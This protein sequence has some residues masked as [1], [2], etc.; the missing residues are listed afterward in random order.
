[1]EKEDLKKK[2]DSAKLFFPRSIILASYWFFVY[3]FKAF[4]DDYFFLPLLVAISFLILSFG[5][6]IMTTRTQIILS[7]AFFFVFYQDSGSSLIEV[8]ISGQFFTNLTL[9]SLY[10]WAKNTKTPELKKNTS[11][12][13]QKFL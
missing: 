12:V 5:T 6:D 13:P 1:M 11:L 2:V 4:V 3:F 10:Y 8:L 7:V 9:V